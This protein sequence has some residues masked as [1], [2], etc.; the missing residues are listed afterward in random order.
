[1]P[2]P[3]A[4]PP[5]SCKRVLDHRALDV[6]DRGR[7]AA[8]RGGPRVRCGVELRA[9]TRV[10]C[11]ASAAICGSRCSGISTAPVSAMAARRRISFAS[12][13]HVARPPVEHQVLHRLLG[14]AQAALLELAR[15]RSEEVLGQ[16]RDLLAALAQ[17]R[18]A[19][20]D[21]V[22]AVEEVLAE[23][24]VGDE[25]IEVRVG[26]GDDADVA[27]AAGRGVAERLDLARLEEAQEFGLD[28]EAR[29]RRSRRGT[30]CRRRRRG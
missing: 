29:A 28:V 15:A 10:R 26:R 7:H 16:R 2:R 21:D 8:G 17:R 6:L 4:R 1:M 18:H 11:G 30:G 24:A 19:A 27:R 5:H 12:C 13:A 3:R 9:R 20:A 23:A 14:E 25:L 22:Q